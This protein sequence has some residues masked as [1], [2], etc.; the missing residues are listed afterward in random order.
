[1]SVLIKDLDMPSC[2]GK[3]F[4]LDDNGDYPTCRITGETRGYTFRVRELRMDKCPFVE[5]KIPP[6]QRN[7][8]QAMNDC[9]S[10]DAVERFIENGLNN[11]DKEKAF[12]HDAV[13]ILTEVHYMNAADVKPVEIIDAGI[14]SALQ[15]L[16]GIRITDK[17]DYSNYSRLH[18]AISLIG[19]DM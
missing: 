12:G 5:V 11:P 3:C 14:K 7:E 9:I 8:A 2:C 1:M 15:I 17:I 13:E 16:D 10:R 6:F 4:A 19:S 18:D